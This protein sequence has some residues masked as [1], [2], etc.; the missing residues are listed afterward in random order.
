[1]S[2]LEYAPPSSA[3][4]ADTVTPHP[5]ICTTAPASW[6]VWPDADPPACPPFRLHHSIGE[7]C[8]DK[9]HVEMVTVVGYPGDKLPGSAWSSNC[10]VLVRRG[11]AADRLLA[12]VHTRCSVAEGCQALMCSLGAVPCRD[13]KSVV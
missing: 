1:M 8:G 10:S 9:E 12:D 3:L 4:K 13:R 6:R 2:R 11:A 5:M 7:N